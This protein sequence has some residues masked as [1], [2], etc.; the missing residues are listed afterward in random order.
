MTN[1]NV[2]NP[3]YGASGIGAVRAFFKNYLNFNGRSTRSEFWWALFLVGL[4]VMV[5]ALILIA[6]LAPGL[7]KA[8][9]QQGASG[10]ML[11]GI[12]GIIVIGGL[13]TLLLVGLLSLACRRFRDVGLS[14]WIF[15]AWVLLRFGLSSYLDKVPSASASV[16]LLSTVVSVAGLLVMV[17]PSSGKQA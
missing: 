8:L 3:Y 17:L 6:L 15:L 1:A 13:G 4:A 5:P 11:G 16:T 2:N 9:S 7:F 12:G 14:G 10:L